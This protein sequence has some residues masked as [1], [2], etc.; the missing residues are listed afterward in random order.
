MVNKRDENIKK[1]AAYHR[2]NPVIQTILFV[3]GEK[4]PGRIYYREKFCLSHLCRDVIRKHLLQMSQVN[5][6]A[7]VPKLKL[8]EPLQ[9]LL[10]YNVS[11]EDA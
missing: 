8:P 1:N 10:L 11:L 4:E 9:K 6:F 2:Y 5:L 3:A 7:S